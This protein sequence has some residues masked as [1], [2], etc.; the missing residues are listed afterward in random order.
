MPVS[1]LLAK[2]DP[3]DQTNLH[4]KFKGYIFEGMAIDERD[5]SKL[6]NICYELEKTYTVL[7]KFT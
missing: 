3:A 2:I 4:R 6:L 7:H 1:K 5:L